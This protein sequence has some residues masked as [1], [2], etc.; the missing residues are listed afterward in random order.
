VTRAQIRKVFLAN[1]FTIKEGLDDLK[2]Y[3]YEAA[4]ALLRAHDD[5]RAEAEMAH[6]SRME[7]HDGLI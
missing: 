2:E 6:Y 7:Q 5:E 1:G 3:V 4:E